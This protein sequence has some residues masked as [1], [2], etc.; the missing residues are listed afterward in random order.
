MD[1][2]MDL[3]AD[4]NKN[5]AESDSGVYS[6]KRIS[7][8]EDDESEDVVIKRK[9]KKKAKKE[10]EESEEEDE[11]DNRPYRKVKHTFEI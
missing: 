4:L 1:S 3:A 7:E 9:K 8:E 2:A 6:Q 11:K 10:E 5:K